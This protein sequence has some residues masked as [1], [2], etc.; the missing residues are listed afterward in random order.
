M[1]EAT[2]QQTQ[3][4]ADYDEDDHFDQVQ[5]EAQ[6]SEAQTEANPKLCGYLDENS[7][8]LSKYVVLLSFAI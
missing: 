8:N 4:L 7:M 6:Q 3:E 1:A 2:D 5:D